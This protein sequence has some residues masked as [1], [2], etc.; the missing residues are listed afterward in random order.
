MVFHLKEWKQFETRKIFS[1]IK[2][3]SERVLKRFKQQNMV[4]HFGV[5]KVDLET[6]TLE[7]LLQQYPTQS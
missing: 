1:Q 5:K 2:I 4:N 7:K 3:E 6:H